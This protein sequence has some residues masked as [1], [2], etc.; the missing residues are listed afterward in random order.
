MS[1]TVFTTTS[2][3][4]GGGQYMIG[5]KQQVFP[6]G[7]HAEYEEYETISQ[8]LVDAAHVNDLQLALELVSH[9]S[10]DV[11]FIGTV[12]LKSRKTEVVLNGESASEVRIEFEEF[13][14]DVTALFL[15][16][17]NGNIA[18]VRNCW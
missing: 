13:R 5:R 18:L 7:L 14:T 16:A 3:G 4:G 15:A 6:V 2:A 1:T 9:P 12:C 10:V 17:H 11:S 8:R